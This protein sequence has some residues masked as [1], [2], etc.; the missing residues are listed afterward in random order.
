MIIKYGNYKI[1]IKAKYDIT[2]KETYTKAQT[3]AVLY[4]LVNAL[5]DSATFMECQGF[6]AIAKSRNDKA[7]QIHEQLQ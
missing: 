5:R 4:E 3:E 2:G 7:N 6:N 1:D